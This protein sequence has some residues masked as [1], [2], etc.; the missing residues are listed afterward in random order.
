MQFA[1]SLSL[2]ISTL[3]ATHK[4]FTFSNY[5]KQPNRHSTPL[6]E[7]FTSKVAPLYGD[8]S[9][10]LQQ[11]GTAKHRTCEVMESKGKCYGV[12]AY[13]NRLR[14]IEGIKHKSF[15]VRNL[16]L[17]KDKPA[18]ER[19]QVDLLRRILTIAGD[20]NASNVHFLVSNFRR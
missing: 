17:M 15:E 7:I 20:L 3:S 11:F 14:S 5:A 13:C 8:Q 1:P 19:Y 9:F 2:S 16:F 10:N 18:H 12:I 4:P 6:I